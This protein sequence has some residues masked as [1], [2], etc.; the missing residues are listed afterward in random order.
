MR[1]GITVLIAAVATGC[2]GEPT[3]PHASPPSHAAAAAAGTG[4]WVARAKYPIDVFDAAGASV[5]DK[6]TG[7][8]TLYLIGGYPACCGAGR[9]SSAVKAYDP[10]ANSWSARASYPVRVHATNGA[11]ELNG[12]IYVTGGFTR[13]WDEPFGVWRRE[14]LNRLYVYSPGTNSWVRKRDMP[15]TA[16]NGASVAYQGRLY[17]AA[18][19]TVWRYDP[20]TDQWAEFGSRPRDWWNASA[21][22]IGGKLYLVEEFGGAMDV[23]DLAT[24][25]WTSGPTRPYR[26]CNAA[27]TSFQAKLYLFGYCDDY[28]ADPEIR[29]RGLVFDPATGGWSEVTPAPIPAGASSALARVFVNE[30]PRLSLVEGVRPANHQQFIP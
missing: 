24:G 19:G 23:L 29:E 9:I 22:V 20:G 16:V 26:A 1:R 15:V 2:G 17:V 14:S 30:Q 21:G 6:A 18:E 12:K 8:T 7:R 11:V 10:S 13:R 25:A 5:T 4:S 27:S 3:A 28:P